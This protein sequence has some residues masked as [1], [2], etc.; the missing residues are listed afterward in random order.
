LIAWGISFHK[1][2]LARENLEDSKHTTTHIVL[3]GAAATASANGTRP[4][5]VTT[6]QTNAQGH[7]VY[8]TTASAKPTTSTKGVSASGKSD[9]GF[10]DNVTVVKK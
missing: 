6:K 3:N 5:T 8:V 9:D 7:V 10:N 4:A 1:R 2:E